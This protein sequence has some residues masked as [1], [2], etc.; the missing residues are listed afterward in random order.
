MHCMSN[1]R[2]SSYVTMPA[3]SSELLPILRCTAIETRGAVV[4]DSAWSEQARQK[5]ASKE[6]KLYGIDLDWAFLQ[7]T[8]CYVQHR[9]QYQLVGKHMGKIFA[10]KEF[11][12]S[13]VPSSFQCQ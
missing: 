10:K 3:P 13:A 6:L 1:K 5:R 2:L 4:Q 12:I 7:K 9:I 8:I 11:R